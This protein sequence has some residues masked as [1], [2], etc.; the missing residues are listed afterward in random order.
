MSRYAATFANPASPSDARPTTL[1]IV[2]DEGTKGKLASKV[3]VIT[4]TS[5]SLGIKTT[6]ALTQIGARLILTTRNLEKAKTALKSILEPSRVDLIAI[7]NTSLESVRATTK[8]VLE[9]SGN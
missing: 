3:I 9:I 5:S 2:K 6:R 8:E 7:D 4:R 1:Q